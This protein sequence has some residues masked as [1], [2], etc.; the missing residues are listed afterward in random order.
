MEVEW[1]PVRDPAAQ[2]VWREVLRPIAAQ[3]RASAADLAEFTVTRIRADAPELLP[4]AQTVAEVSASTGESL[5][6]LA[7]VIE[8][9]GDPRR[10]ELPPSSLAIVRSAVWRQVPVADHLRFYRLAHEH[11]WRWLYVRITAAARDAVEQ[12]TAVELATG[13]LFAFADHGMTQTDH[14]YG[15][16]RE[17]WLRGATATRAAAI[18]DI[19]ADRERDGQAASRRLRYD[20]TRHHIGVI[21]WVDNVPDKGDAL[22]LLT[23]SISDAARSVGAQ[24]SITHPMGS[25]AVAGWIS[26]RRAFATE[27]MDVFGNGS[28]PAGVCVA[29]GEPR[30]DLNGFRRTHLE[31][32]HAR[33]VASLVAPHGESATRYRDVAVAALC[34]ADSDHALAFATRILG[35]LAAGDEA[36]FRLATTLEA[37]LHENRSRTR[38]AARLAV[39]PNTVSYRVHRAEELLGRNVSADTLD[40]RVA[41][42]LLPALRRLEQA[43]SSELEL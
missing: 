28:R 30:H 16:E 40:L 25:L 27:A 42:T 8:L 34:T 10:T 17:T 9:G 5:R 29:V 15:V 1:P 26:S 12:A 14:A 11:V 43:R 18:E 4:D 13:W 33:R 23:E 20:V 39:H 3:M 24:S 31:A 2:R 19:I 6:L 21:A 35:P 36:T 37:Y 7:Q 32:G 22:S 38:A 41:L